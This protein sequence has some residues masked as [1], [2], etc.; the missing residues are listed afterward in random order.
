MAPALAKELGQPVASFGPVFAGGLSG[1]IIGSL[2]I[3]PLADRFG[4]KRLLIVAILIF[5]LFTLAPTLDLDY[6]RLIIY[7]FVTG[8]GLGSAMPCAITLTT[9]FAP[10]RYR[11]LLTNSMFVGF[12][13]GGAIAG[14]TAGHFL[15]DQ[16]WRS[17]FLIGS[18]VPLLLVLPIA[19][20]LPESVTFLASRGLNRA[21]I[22]AILSRLDRTRTY[23][24]AEEFTMPSARARSARIGTLFSPDLRLG[25]V[26][27]WGV[28][29]CTLF[30][31]FS[32]AS[33]LPAMLQ[34]AGAAPERAVRGPVLMLIGG[35]LGGI[36]FGFAIDRLGA[37]RFLAGAY[38]LA[39]VFTALLGH[40][41][42]AFP[43]ALVLI[44]LCGF[45]NVGGQLSINGLAARFYPIEV[46]ST[47]VGWALGLGRF[48]A[49]IGP[50][51]G[52]W[53]LAAHW[54]PA[55]V[56]GVIGFACLVSAACMIALGLVYGKTGARQ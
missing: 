56:F 48:G 14:L 51:T 18:I 50:V 43:I 35:V 53:M 24:A 9:E 38:I 19:F 8:L 47:G 41:L 23:N 12:P 13:L 46:R 49:I 52:G 10:R 25:T 40:A 30:A 39:A 31:L 33:W 2:F 54:S 15:A 27:L 28:F 37:P 17:V 45:C 22:A 6:G 1:L 32:L 16:D 44:F 42:D 34:E 11:A 20:F 4:R 21:G 36:T 5:G 55:L 29:F 3:S 26:L 7:R